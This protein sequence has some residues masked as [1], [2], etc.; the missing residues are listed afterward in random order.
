MTARTP[1]ARALARV[2]ELGVD[3][4]YTGDRRSER[5]SVYAPRGSMWREFGQ[6]TLCSNT[7]DDWETSAAPAWE[8]ILTDMS[9][10]LVPCTIADC[11]MC[12]EPGDVT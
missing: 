7:D 2:R 5:I 12:D 1:R 4:D 8:S 9:G 10:G 3:I 11:D 6:H